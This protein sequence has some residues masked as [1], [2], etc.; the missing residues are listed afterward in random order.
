M[1]GLL[2]CATMIAASDD[3][4]GAATIAAAKEQAPTA[5]LCSLLD[6]DCVNRLVPLLGSKALARLATVKRSE[7]LKVES[8]TR[9]QLRQGGRLSSL[10]IHALI[11]Q[12]PNWSD[13]RSS[14]AN[15]WR[16][17]KSRDIAHLVREE[18]AEVN[19]VDDENQTPLEAIL[20]SM[21]GDRMWGD[22]EWKKRS[23]SAKTLLALGA[24]PDKAFALAL[25]GG[26]YRAAE[27]LLEFGADISRIP[28]ED[29]VAV[30]GFLTYMTNEWPWPD[31]Y[32]WR[33]PRVRHAF[34]FSLM[35][36]RSS[37]VCLTPST[38]KLIRRRIKRVWLNLADKLFQHEFD[39]RRGVFFE[40]RH[41]ELMLNRYTVQDAA[42]QITKGWSLDE[43][44]EDGEQD[45]DLPHYFNYFNIPQKHEKKKRKKR[46]RSQKHTR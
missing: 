22:R 30:S 46:R 21:E 7:L 5:N 29:H 44:S 3:R 26:K 20:T 17:A 32:D 1:L 15:A 12:V 28:T 39:P 13:P 14:S 41:F 9:K 38:A 18:G 16:L 33:T 6:G 31:S 19:F 27:A 23:C 36:G 24:D 40:R 37:A 43:S 35:H 2:L 4:G 45:G 25:R 42:L 34:Q 11:R 8:R 10:E